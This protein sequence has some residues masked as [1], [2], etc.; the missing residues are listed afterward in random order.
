VIFT[1]V[2]SGACVETLVYCPELLTSEAA[3]H[4][5]RGSEEDG[6]RRQA[7]TADIFASI[8]E[9]DNPV[10]LA[11]IVQTQWTE[12]EEVTVEADDIVVALY[13]T[14]EPGNLG[15]TLRTMDAVGAKK[16]V[17]VGDS[18]DPFHPSAVKA[19]MGA[20]F[21]VNIASVS[22]IEQLLRWAAEKR[23]TTVA[24]SAKAKTVYTEAEYV[25][26]VLLLLGNEGE[27]LPAAALDACDLAV[28]IPMA[29]KASSLNLAVAAGLLLYAIRQSG[30]R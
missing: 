14:S 18:V 5:I 26:P 28:T 4:L 1:A 19:S 9:R 21:T 16:V 8:S 2:E 25:L 6:I 30:A 10:G 23:L 12:L 29:G 24:S 3:W 15:T 27:G 22:T 11:A 7:V 17:L 20:L 13:Q